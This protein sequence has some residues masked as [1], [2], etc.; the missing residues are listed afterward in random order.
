MNLKQQAKL[1]WL[2]HRLSQGMWRWIGK[3]QGSHHE[4]Y[5]Q[6]PPCTPVLNVCRFAH[7]P[8]STLKNSS[9]YISWSAIAL[10][11]KD[12]QA[13]NLNLNKEGS[14]DGFYKQGLILLW[15]GL[16]NLNYFLVSHKKKSER[17]DFCISLFSEINFSLPYQTCL[18]FLLYHIKHVKC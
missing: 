3:Q 17:K 18:K 2:L 9:T 4:T 10:I 8:S 12:M 16:F 14:I 6:N 1:P 7:N 5:N 11:Y 13:H 15:P